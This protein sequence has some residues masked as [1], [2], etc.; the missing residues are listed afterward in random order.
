MELPL[1]NRNQGPIAEAEAKRAEAAARFLAVQ[2]KV[3]AAID[4]AVQGHAATREQYENSAAVLEAQ[5]RQAEALE[6]A[7]K[8]G[9]A[10]RIEAVSARLEAAIAELAVLDAEANSQRALGQLEDALQIPFE[11]LKS[12]EQGR[13]DQAM[14]GN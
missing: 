6:A 12:V 5:R 9:G 14:K 10:D 13:K 1:L 3:I 4:R 7:F 8:A 11:A 2:A